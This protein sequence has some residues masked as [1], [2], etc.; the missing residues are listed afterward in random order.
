M[1]RVLFFG[2]R[3]LTWKHLWVAKL[4]AAH[5]ACT[6]TPDLGYWLEAATNPEDDVWR[7]ERITEQL[8]LIHGD[9]PPGDTPGAV[10]ADKLSE[11]A[12]METWPESQRRVRRF[13]VRP[14]DGEAWKVAAAKRD[15]AMAEAKPDLA[16]CIH[17]DLDHS[18]GSIITAHA[19]QD[20]QRRFWYVRVSPAGELLSVEE[21]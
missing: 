14:K 21:R 13:P 4:C 10:G 15:V 9:G 12:C 1:T 5:A 6:G 20:R 7:C 16:Y 2:S 19:L 8:T 3:N 11:F 18:K 17:T